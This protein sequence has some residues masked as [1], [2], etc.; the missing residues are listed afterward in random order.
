MVDDAS[1]EEA[2]KEAIM[3][4]VAAGSIM[5]V[6]ADDRHADCARFISTPLVSLATRDSP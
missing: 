1:V 3:P 2:I 4:L 6:R 5:M